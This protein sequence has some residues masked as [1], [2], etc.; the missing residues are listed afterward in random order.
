MVTPLRTGPPQIPTEWSL[1]LPE[2][3]RASVQGRA[4]LRP[5]SGQPT[6]TPAQGPSP[7]PAGQDV[8]A[9]GPD[10]AAPVRMARPGS[11]VDIRI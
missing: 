10:P 6:R 9:A 2:S 7:V 3:P 4:D 5:E 11:L 1:R 8:R